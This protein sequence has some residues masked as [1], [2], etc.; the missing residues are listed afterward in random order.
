MS[1][2]SWP[3]PQGQK[4]GR[5]VVRALIVAGLLC[6]LAFTGIAL[7][8]WMEM[9]AGGHQG[10]GD[11]SF[12]ISRDAREIVFNAAGS[13]GSRD[14]YVLNLKTGDVTELVR[15][16]KYELGPS[17]SAD[18]QEV[19]YSA[20]VDW[21]RA[22]HQIYSVRRS[23]RRV[24][25]I[26]AHSDVSDH[27]PSS[28]PDGSTILFARAHRG[29]TALLGNTLWDAWD[30][31]RVPSGGGAVERLTHEEFDGISCPRYLA[32]G[33]RIVFSAVPRTGS[34]IGT[35]YVL[36]IDGQRDLRALRTGEWAAQA[37]PSPD[38]VTAAFIQANHVYT[39]RL[40]GTRMA[41]LTHGDSYELFPRYAP[42]GSGIYYLSGTA[43]VTE[44]GPKY[45]VV[46]MA[47]AT[48]E[49]VLVARST[50]FDRPMA[51]SRAGAEK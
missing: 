26:T 9:A 31:C 51:Y 32:D 40:D 44:G 5:S 30:V 12:D 36:S 22:R 38:G 20:A 27:S 47:L 39:I 48:R 50:L 10:A 7:Y 41:S 23:D 46:K 4:R 21:Y 43:L 1:G 24:R 6:V 45:D 15:T 17:F 28:S 3:S 16:P 8:R 37:T 11:L 14:L 35:T 25:T 19:L 13:G 2:S 34:G 42:D 18:D 33:K 49:T 29:R